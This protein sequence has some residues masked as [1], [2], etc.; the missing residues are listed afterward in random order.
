MKIL[1]WFDPN[2]NRI[3]LGVI[4]HYELRH[5]LTKCHLIG[6]PSVSEASMD[7]GSSWN[8]LVGL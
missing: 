5:L 8:I 2:S 1:K 3:D 4:L 7:Q 6:L